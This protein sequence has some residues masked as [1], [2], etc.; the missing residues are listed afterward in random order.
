MLFDW[1]PYIRD[2]LA[3]ERILHLSESDFEAVCQR[4]WSIQDHARRV[5]NA[6]LNLPG[7][8]RYDMETKTKELAHFL[9]DAAHRRRFGNR[10]IAIARQR[11]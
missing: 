7:G 8:Q 2:A 11:C 6:T 1:A 9:A 4:V 3:R 10:Y 5:A